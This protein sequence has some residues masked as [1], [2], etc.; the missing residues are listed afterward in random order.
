MI[1][2]GFSADMV[3]SEIYQPKTLRTT[4]LD[5]VASKVPAWPYIAQKVIEFLTDNKLK[6]ALD[7]I[8]G[9]NLKAD[10]LIKILNSFSILYE[11][12]EGF[13]KTQFIIKT[14]LT[15]TALQNNDSIQELAYVLELV[16]IYVYKTSPINIRNDLKVVFHELINRLVE[17]HVTFKNE[18]GDNLLRAIPIRINGSG[19]YDIKFLIDTGAF[20]INARISLGKDTLLDLA[21]Q[22]HDPGLVQYLLEH[23]ANPSIKN[24]TGQT[25][26]DIAKKELARTNSGNMYQ[27][28]RQILKH[29]IVAEKKQKEADAAASRALEMHKSFILKPH[30]L[31][32]LKGQLGG[33]LL[34]GGQSTTAQASSNSSGSSSQAAVASTE[35][36]GQE[37]IV[38]LSS[39]SEER[40]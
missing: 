25:A 39:S 10:D 9:M 16:A 12:N 20:N 11:G 34:G 1:G 32:G 6:K 30:Q 38:A 15:N 19:R 13:L 31:Q 26:I 5:Y 29:L 8:T 36:A 17:N 40:S 22:G 18:L 24:S 35:T 21:I 33:T 2:P 3:S 37:S 28:M 4:A 7:Y 27:R 14:I 23:G